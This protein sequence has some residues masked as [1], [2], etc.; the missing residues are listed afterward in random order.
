[1]KISD[2]RLPKP[3]LEFLESKGYKELYPPQAKAVNA[4]LLSGNSV[5]VSAPT[6]SGKT[7]IAAIAMFNHLAKNPNKVIVYLSPLRALAAEKYE[8][9]KGIE[10]IQLNKNKKSVKKIKISISTGDFSSRGINTTKK[11]SKGDDATSNV[12]FL[13]NEKMDSMIRHDASW[14]DK[15]GLVIVDEV[16]L[17]GDQDRGATLEMV[18]A[19][20]KH[21]DTVPQIVGLSATITNAKEIAKWL[22]C[23]LVQSSWRPVHLYEGAYEDGEVTLTSLNSKKKKKFKIETSARGA[24]VD[25]GIHTIKQGGQSLVF[26]ETRTRSASIATKASDVIQKLLDKQEINL[27]DKTSRKILQE[28]EHTEL[29]KKLAELVK[30][31]VAFHHAGLNQKCRQAVETEFRNGSIKLVSSTPTLAAGVNLPARRVVISTV[32]RYDFKEGYN[33]PIS[34]LEYKQLSGRAGR[35]QYDDYGESIVVTGTT[36]STREIMRSYV[37]AKPEPI[38]SQITNEKSL[39]IHV[40]SVIATNPGFKEEQIIDLFLDTLGGKQTRRTSMKFAIGIALRFLLR[41]KLVIKKGDRYAATKFGKKTS[42]LYIDP[43]TAVYFKNALEYTTKKKSYTLGF[44][45]LVSESEE[46]FPKF[47]LRNTDY[48]LIN[49]M[50]KNHKKQLIEPISI[51]DC[52]RSLLGLHYWITEHTERFLADNIKIESGDMHRMVENAVWLI[53]CLREIAKEFD[54]ADLLTELDILQKRVIHG[55][56]EELVELVEI[57][58]V[59]RVR[60]RALYKHGIKSIDDVNKTSAKKLANIDKIGVTLAN[61]IKTGVHV[62]YKN[63]RR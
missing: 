4:G 25:L 45:H 17:I 22:G 57:K 60:S 48:R 39:R 62:R 55:I 8:D 10:K 23:T 31:G 29:V 16:H 27:L 13:T 53:Y 24:A 19:R 59:G 32:N 42:K 49:T 14:I 7:L 1:M 5:L 41:E 63:K 34:V 56:K 61:K 47:S 46:F 18:L 44:L 6:A 52:N 33:K 28:N 43:Q 21:L 54:H 15:I 30:Q 11:I 36:N 20:L 51:Y 2:L 12:L 37:K 26:A 50:I 35:P 40:L 58:G 3:A 9:L 38:Q